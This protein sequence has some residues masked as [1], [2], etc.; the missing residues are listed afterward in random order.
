MKSKRLLPLALTV[1]LCLTLGIARS[2]GVDPGVEYQTET[3]GGWLIFEN[4]FNITALSYSSDL[5]IFTDFNESGEDYFGNLGFQVPAGCN[6][7]VTSVKPLELNFTAEFITGTPTIRVHVPSKGIPT[8]VIGGDWSFFPFLCVGLPITATAN[9]SLSWEDIPYYEEDDD[10]SKP[11][12]TDPLGSLIN[13]YLMEGDITGMIIATYT[14]QLGMFFFTI[15]MLIFSVAF[16]NRLG[17]Q[18]TAILWLL[19]WG[20]FSV[21][22]PPRA[23]NLVVILLVTAVGLLIVTLFFSRRDKSG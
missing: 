7:T 8:S 2:I 18:L 20:T 17:P 19:A 16:Y 15:V 23:I 12:Y 9:Y 5:L 3:G 6:I 13:T 14:Y 10:Y 21:V 1:W 4:A 11:T 22:F